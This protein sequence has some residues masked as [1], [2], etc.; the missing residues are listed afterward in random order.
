ME[1]CPNV[2]R[3]KKMRHYDYNMNIIIHGTI[4][5]DRIMSFPR[6]FTENIVPDKIHKLSVSFYIDSMNV[7]RGGTGG[8]IA[9]NLGLLGVPSRIITGVG[10]DASEYLELL[11]KMNVDVSNVGVH[12]DVMTP[13]CSIITD[14]ANNQITAFYVGAAARETHFDFSTCDPADTLVIL[15]PANNT[16]DTLKYV[17][18]CKEYGLKYIFDPGQTIGDYNGK[19]LKECIQGSYM[20]TANDYEIDLALSKMG[21]EEEHLLERTAVLVTT[22]GDKGSVIK[23]QDGA[24]IDIDALPQEHIV[25]PTGA[26]DAYRAGLIAGIAAGAS[27]ENSGRLAACAA[28]FAIEQVGTQEHSYTMDDFRDRYTTYFEIDCIL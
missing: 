15:A 21:L 7:L 28:S 9:Y 24:V 3:S 4:A 8:N 25:D 18:A 17:A 13:Y 20:F 6:Y 27:L 2:D 26:G 11:K 19:Q 16:A 23:T 12:K 10:T 5:Y 22:L 1:A 14:R